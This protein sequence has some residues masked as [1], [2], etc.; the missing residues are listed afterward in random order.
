MAKNKN[1]PAR[2]RRTPPVAVTTSTAY[3]AALALAHGDSRRLRV[4]DATT[5]VVENS[6]GPWPNRKRRA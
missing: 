4:V 2:T 3:P 1:T 6:P 5:V